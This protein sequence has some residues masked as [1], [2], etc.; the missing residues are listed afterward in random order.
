MFLISHKLRELSSFDA[1]FPVLSS[2]ICSPAHQLYT[3]QDLLS[4]S[5]I[6]L[7]LI[8]DPRNAKIVSSFRPEPRRCMQYTGSQTMRT[9]TL[10]RLSL[11]TSN[12]GR[13]RRGL[14][15]RM[16]D[17]IKGKMRLIKASRLYFRQYILC[18]YPNIAFLRDARI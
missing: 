10:A 12:I 6:A 3:M 17:T 15:R 11:T 4:T 5:D 1:L 9:C 2:K 7:Q 18:L 16:S 13:S 8:L 14:I